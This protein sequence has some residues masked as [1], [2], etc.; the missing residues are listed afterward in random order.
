MH[1]EYDLMI[2]LLFR[3][4]TNFPMFSYE[5]IGVGFIYSIC[6]NLVPENNSTRNV[7]DKCRL[8]CRTELLP[9]H[10]SDPKWAE[11]DIVGGDLK[12]PFS[13][14]NSAPQLCSLLLTV[15]E[16]SRFKGDPKCLVGRHL[17]KE[18]S[19]SKRHSK[20]LL[21]AL[22]QNTSKNTGH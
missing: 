2:P 22:S 19:E 21:K 4:K 17:K 10:L 11:R 1:P 16:L 8:Y 20:T 14:L 18:N 3:Q 7:S 12:L 5:E 13:P 9:C 6:L 15:S